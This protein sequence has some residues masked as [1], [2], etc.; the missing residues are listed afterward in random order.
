MSSK[1]KTK[2]TNAQAI[3]TRRARFTKALFRQQ[4]IMVA[5]IEALEDMRIVS[6]KTLKDYAIGQ[7]VA[8]GLCDFAHKWTIYP[9]VLCESEIGEQYLKI[10][11]FVTQNEHKNSALAGVVEGQ[12]D[13]LVSACNH[14]HVKNRAWLAAPYDVDLTESRIGE[15]VKRLGWWG[16]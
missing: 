14:R 6:H 10:D 15:I 4:G 13:K 16:V 7:L 5:H 3:A 9:L 8:D 12:V 11:C 1:K 2:K